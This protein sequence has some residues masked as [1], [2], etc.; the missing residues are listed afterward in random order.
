MS[1][2]IIADL[3]SKNKAIYDDG[4]MNVLS[5]GKL[6]LQFVEKMS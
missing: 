5:D 2:G 3:I 1:Q 4:D 6:V